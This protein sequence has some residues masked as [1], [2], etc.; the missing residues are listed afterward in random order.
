MQLKSRQVTNKEKGKNCPQGKKIQIESFTLSKMSNR[1]QNI[2]IH[3]RKQQC[4]SHSGGDQSIETDFKNDLAKTSK[5]LLF[6]S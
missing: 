6:F 2:T 1:Q 4:D 3:T 5:L